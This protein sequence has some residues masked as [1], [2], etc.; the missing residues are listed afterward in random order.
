MRLGL[1]SHNLFDVAWA[2][3]LPDVHRIEFEMLEGMA[4]AQSRE[5]RSRVD[6]MLLYAPVV[7]RDDLPASIAYL[8]RRLD[9]NTSPDN[10]LRALF[11]L[12]PGTAEWDDQCRR[13]VAAVVAKDSVGT[14][15]RRTQE[16]AAFGA[17]ASSVG[18]AELR[19]FRN[20][21]DTDWTVASN[22]EWIARA[23]RTER[24]E[25][26]E[27]VDTA[28]AI[29]DVVA[30]AVDAAT[31]WRAATWTTRRSVLAAVADEMERSRGRTIALMAQTACKTV[32]EGDPEVSEA[33]DFARYYGWCTHRIEQAE[34]HGRRFTPAGVVL[35][36]SP[37]NFPYAIPAGGVLAALA[38]GNAVVLKPAPEVREVA[39]ELAQQLWRAG[40][41]RA[42]VQFVA[43]PDDEVGRGS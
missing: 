22:R 36:A 39:W 33:V 4:T 27:T 9:E 29:D 28:G 43:C 8:T 30:A 42:L 11:T 23:L 12:R 35:V 18:D 15:S 34:A 3:G 1:A 14:L 26:F 6:G 38:A 2:M 25:A 37:W 41:P 21:P 13:F 20:A 10:F 7:R 24:P 31:V 5:V 19:E 32:G 40:V 17:V 16:R